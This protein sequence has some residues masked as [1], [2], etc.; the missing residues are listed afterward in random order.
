MSTSVSFPTIGG[1]TY[2]VPAAGE[3]SWANL[4]NYLIA[5][6]QAQ[7]TTSQKVGSRIATSTPVTVASATDCLV[8]TDLAVAGAV[9]VNLPAG[10]NG[11]LYA[12]L[13][14][15]GDAATNNITIT[16]NGAETIDST[17]SYVLSKNR[18]S[19]LLM[20]RGTNWYIVAEF[21]NIAGGAIARNLIAAATPG[22][23]VINDG[24][25][26]LLSEEQFLNR[27]RGGTGIT[28][29]AVFPSSGD[30]I[31][32]TSTDTGANRLQNKSLDDDSVN[33]VDSGDTTKVLEVEVSGSTTGTTTTL[34]TSSTANRTL[35][36]PDGTTTLVGRTTSD[37]GAS[38]LQ[39]KDLD[40]SNTKFVDPTDTTKT[41]NF[42]ASG[43]STGTS[44]T[45]TSVATGNR[46]YT[47]PDGTTTLVGTNVFQTIT[48]KDIDGG[49]ASNQRRITVPS[50]TFATISGLTRK[51]GTILYGTDTLGLY[52]DD[53][54]NLVLLAGGPA[55][56]AMSR[57]FV[58]TGGGSAATN[59]AIGTFTT[60]VENVGSDITYV[61]DSTLGDTFTV[62]TAGLYSISHTNNF[63]TA[64]TLG[65][66]RN[67][68]QLSTGIQ[69]ITAADALSITTTVSN[70]NAANCAVTIF[71][72]A[73]DVIRAH[74]APAFNQGGTATSVKF[75]MQRLY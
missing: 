47:L 55:P 57:V 60:V 3:V 44:A 18:A 37:T 10:V 13:D 15:K 39:N 74:C 73:S 22:Y 32:R 11:Q 49:A 23:V 36:L 8:I 29:T 16:P 68:S 54:T 46:V 62:N 34:A 25:T 7:G 40:A 19:V 43:A 53:G 21:T 50:G 52:Y 45:L 14:G 4:S 72:D 71:L 64:N 17:T 6:A 59:T 33:F 38:R 65:I 27:T 58:T 2:S 69:S 35:T 31:T 12:I 20:F 63:N 67:S 42:N 28:S 75:I 70:D 48:E 66:S 24:T 61:S 26:G 51:A 41:V 56:S 5:L 1:T 30:I 9:A